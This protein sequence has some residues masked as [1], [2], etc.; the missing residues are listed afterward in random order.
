MDNGCGV[1]FFPVEL[2][3]FRELVTDDCQSLRTFVVEFDAVAMATTD[4]T[5]LET[6]IE[7]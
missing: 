2:A 5:R 4:N 7:F 6:R 3:M 1:E